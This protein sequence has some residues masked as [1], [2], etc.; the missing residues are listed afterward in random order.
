MGVAG[1]HGALRRLQ[2]HQDGDLA[3]AGIVDGAEH[4]AHDAA[5]LRLGRRLDAGGHQPDGAA[6]GAGQE[7]AS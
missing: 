1:D 6:D 5:G 3:V 4:L 2:R 7:S